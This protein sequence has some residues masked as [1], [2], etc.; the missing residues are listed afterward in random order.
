MSAVTSWPLTTCTSQPKASHL[1]SSGS[2]VITLKVDD[3]MT[4]EPLDR[5]WE[6][7]GWDVHC[8]DGHDVVALAEVLR[9]IKADESRDRP[10]CVIARTVKG[11]GVSYMEAEPGWHLGYLN[12]RTGSAQRQKSKR[13]SELKCRRLFSDSWQYRSLNALNPGTSFFRK[14]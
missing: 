1:R 6:A 3:V 12:P 5:K 2:I 14:D 7:F 13:Q 10:A 11:K 8:V 4:I 9:R